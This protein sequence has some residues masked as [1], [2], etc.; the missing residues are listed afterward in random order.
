MNEES[1]G[2]MNRYV[3]SIVVN[4]RMWQILRANSSGNGAGR[5]A[6]LRWG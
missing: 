5:A 6:E 1:H 2:L 4:T 3:G